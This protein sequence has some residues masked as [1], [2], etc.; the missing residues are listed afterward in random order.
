MLA[1]LPTFFTDTLSLNLTQAA[2]VG[3]TSAPPPP[4]PRPRLQA[5]F[6]G[7]EGSNRSLTLD[8]NT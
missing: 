3:A 4:P 6:E 7:E 2:Q 1:W 5:L 8:A